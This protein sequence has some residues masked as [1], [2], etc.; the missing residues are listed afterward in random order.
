VAVPDVQRMVEAAERAA[1]AD[2]GWDTPAW[3][4]AMSVWAHERAEEYDRRLYAGS[5]RP[6]DAV[7]RDW[8]RQRALIYHTFRIL[9]APDADGGA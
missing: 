6:D 8:V 3:Y 5:G 1:A 9:N 4:T 2:H 7:D